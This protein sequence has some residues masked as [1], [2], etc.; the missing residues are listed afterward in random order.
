MFGENL[1]DSSPFCFVIDGV[2]AVAFGAPRRFEVK[3]CKNRHTEERVWV[4]DIIGFSATGQ[5]R[6]Q[7]PSSS[8]AHGNVVDHVGE[9]LD[10][11][12]RAIVSGELLRKDSVH[13]ILELLHKLLLG[14][15]EV[16]CQVP[17]VVIGKLMGSQSSLR[18]LGGFLVF[19]QPG[20]RA[21]KLCDWS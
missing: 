20:F 3:V 6:I 12:R 4:F 7:H 14:P 1:G 2:V 18:I 11:N 13:L 19:V 15:G 8:K 5:V 10:A 17:G 9:D 21:L 16:S